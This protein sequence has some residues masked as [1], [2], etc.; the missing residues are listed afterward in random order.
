MLTTD[1]QKGKFLELRQIWLKMFCARNLLL[2]TKKDTEG[3]IEIHPRTQ[4]HSG[5]NGND[6]INRPLNFAVRVDGN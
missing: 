4:I 1:S 5:D 2:V 6:R 3:E